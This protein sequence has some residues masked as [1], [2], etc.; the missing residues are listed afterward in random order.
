MP[1]TAASIGPV[2]LVGSPFRVNTGTGAYPVSMFLG[3]VETGVP[4]HRL[5]FTFKIIRVL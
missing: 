1:P 2:E 5:S 3:K 4:P